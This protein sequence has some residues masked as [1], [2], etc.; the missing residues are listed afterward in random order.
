M[1]DIAPTNHPG[2]AKWVIV[3]LHYVPIHKDEVLKYATD[4]LLDGLPDIKRKKI[5]NKQ[6]KMQESPDC[7][8]V[9]KSKAIN[10]LSFDFD[11]SYQSKK[12]QPVPK[13]DTK[14]GQS[15]VTL[16]TCN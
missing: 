16:Y 10:D 11:D 15:H 7:V 9:N 3:L 8:P 4:Y 13:E 6:D 1:T 14:Y 5:N 12:C 2:P